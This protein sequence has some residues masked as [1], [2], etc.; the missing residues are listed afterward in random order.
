MKRVPGTVNYN[1]L[2]ASLPVNR[3]AALARDARSRDPWEPNKKIA[4]RHWSAPPR[5]PRR[6]SAV[7][8]LAGR[9]FGHFTVVGYFGPFRRGS[10]WLVRCLCG[11]Y[12]TR[13]SHAVKNPHNCHDRCDKCRTLL[14]L[15][16]EQHYLRTGADVTIQQLEGV[17][18]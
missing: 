6:P 4:Q 1:S 8:D 16:R 11:D 9:K 10:L 18:R 15:R 2:A 14:F 7:P 17:K 12:E 13:K 5:L 3:D